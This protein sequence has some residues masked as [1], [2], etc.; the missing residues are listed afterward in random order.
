VA[1]QL[2]G[3][4]LLRWS[5]SGVGLGHELGTQALVMQ[6]SLKLSSRPPIQALLRTFID[7]VGNPGG[8]EG[9]AGTSRVCQTSGA[10]ADPCCGSALLPANQWDCEKLDGEGIVYRIL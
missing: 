9:G 10:I 3:F 2:N 7:E 5:L 8:D 1:P 6:R 4:A